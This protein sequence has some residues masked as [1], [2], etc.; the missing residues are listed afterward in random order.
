[1]RTIVFIGF[2]VLLMG[3]SNPEYHFFVGGH[4][5][6]V[7]GINNKG[8]HPPFQK[9]ILSYQNDSLVHFGVLTGDIV[10]FASDKEFNEVDSVLKNFTKPIYFVPGNHDLIGN[11]SL[12]YQRY[13]DPYYA[14]RIDDDLFLFLNGNLD[15]WNISG[16]QLAFVK[17]ELSKE[18]DRAFVFIHQVIWYEKANPIIKFNS[19]D[20]KAK[21]LT[22]W[23]TL[24]P[25]FDKSITTYFIAGDVGGG[26][27]SPALHHHQ[28]DN[29]HF[30]AS[31]MGNAID[32]NYL[33]FTVYNNSV[34][35]DVFP[36]E[37]KVPMRV[38]PLDSFPVGHFQ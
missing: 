29:F 12:F 28:L 21:K 18:Y 24:L 7:T 32:E 5:Y 6:G 11:D 2:I 16:E 4:S 31:G 37:T 22:F 35:I 1:M 33:M 27:Y 19:G 23:D 34:K 13:R 10:P 8:L 3:C 14:I 26:K 9:A 17:E 15:H 38:N 25:L 36:L 30:I 20:G